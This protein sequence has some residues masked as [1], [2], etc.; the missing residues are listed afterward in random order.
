LRR[1]RAEFASDLAMTSWSI[2][3]Q[4]G[5]SF[6]SSTNRHVTMGFPCRLFQYLPCAYFIL[7]HH[8]HHSLRMDKHR[9]LG[10]GFMKCVFSKKGTGAVAS[11]VDREPFAD[12]KP[13][14]S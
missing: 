11:A 3:V 2:P 12:L 1:V 9:I 8:A 10:S 6:V 13:L 14:F 7:G 4:C 5:R